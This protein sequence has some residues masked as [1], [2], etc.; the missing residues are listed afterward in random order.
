ML[1][2]N[3]YCDARRGTNKNNINQFHPC[4]HFTLYHIY[5]F[6]AKIPPSGA[7]VGLIKSVN[8]NYCVCIFKGY[9]TDEPQF[10]CGHVEPPKN[11]TIEWAA[12]VYYSSMSCD[13]SYEEKV[14]YMHTYILVRPG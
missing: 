1:V 9:I 6:A 8:N 12:L 5:A 2:E 14:W 13:C 11:S 10:A 7:G 4:K 3:I